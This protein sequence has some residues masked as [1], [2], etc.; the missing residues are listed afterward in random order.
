M[1]EESGIHIIHI[2][3]EYWEVIN[4]TETIIQKGSHLTT[5]YLSGN[6]NQNDSRNENC[7]FDTN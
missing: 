6:L 1:L 2:D 5:T 7:L 4:N 3:E